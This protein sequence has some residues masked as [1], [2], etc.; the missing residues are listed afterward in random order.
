MAD[1]IDRISGA[2]TL[3]I[4]PR[5]KINLHR[6]VAVE[7]LYALGEWSRAEVAAEFDLQ[8]NEAVQ[9]GQ[10]ADVIDA[11]VGV[12]DK[13]LYILRVESVC[14]C[15]ED[16]NDRLYHDVTGVVDKSQ[17]YASLLIAG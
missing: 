1:L 10:L 6:F 3:Q 12:N 9:A 7:R 17:V 13:A 5:P 11:Q 16:S 15:I 8:G 2:S 4:P 14:M